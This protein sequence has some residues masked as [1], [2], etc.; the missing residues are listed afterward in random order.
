ML[1]TAAFRSAH[2]GNA[3][4]SVFVPVILRSGPVRSGPAAAEAWRQLRLW[5]SK[6]V[7]GGLV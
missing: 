5:G 2:A 4:K 1:F 7:S 3:P 6:H